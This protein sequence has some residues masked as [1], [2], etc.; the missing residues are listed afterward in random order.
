MR[1]TEN[2]PLYLIIKEDLVNKINDGEYKTHAMLPPEK[3]LSD[4]YNVSR[5][6][7]RKALDELAKAGLIKRQ[8]GFGTTI[9][10]NREDLKL[11]TMVE[12]FTNEM[13]E[14]GQSNTHTISSTISIVFA[15]EDLMNR[16]NCDFS[17]KIYNLKRV[18]GSDDKPIVF[19]DTWLKLPIDLPTDKEFLYGSLYKYL[20]SENIYFSK[21]E[22]EL[23]AINPSKN[24]RDILK[25]D[26][27]GVVLKRI[28]K[29][30]DIKGN[31]IEYTI[32]YYDAKLYRYT[33]EV[34][35]I[36]QTK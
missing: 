10:H 24:M 2:L 14:S 32:N 36:E 3:T 25:L 5:V 19:S 9:N 18:R 21:F 28:R 23:E 26:K 12:S 15:D 8:A 16:F 17:D 35:S 27:D 13:K 29:G 7:M 1:N 30:F 34:A 20:I 33:V 4:I 22:E 11:F 6:T 31:L